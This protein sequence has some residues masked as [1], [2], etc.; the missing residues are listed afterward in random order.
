[1]PKLR[2][3]KIKGSTVLVEKEKFLDDVWR[4]PVL[5]N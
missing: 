4:V 1:M 2:V 5:M 3:A